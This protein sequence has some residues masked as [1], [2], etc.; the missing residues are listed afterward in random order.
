MRGKKIMLWLPYSIAN[1]AIFL[2]MWVLSLSFFR[3]LLWSKPDSQTTF[4]CLRGWS[5]VIGQSAFFTVVGH[6]LS[7]KYLKLKAK[8]KI[9]AFVAQWKKKTRNMTLWGVSMKPYHRLVCL[10]CLS[11][12]YKMW[13][14]YHTFLLKAG[15]VFHLISGATLSVDVKCHVCQDCFLLSGPL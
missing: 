1:Y 11:V 3:H 14:G 10:S 13:Q 15:A 6:S 5:F 9:V 7:L 4:L 2:D 8:K 12:L